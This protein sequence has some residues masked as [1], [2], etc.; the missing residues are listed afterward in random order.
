MFSR[1][2]GNG[3]GDELSRRVRMW[4]LTFGVSKACWEN[5][6]SVES[7]LMGAPFDVACPFA[8]L[9]RRGR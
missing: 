5:S 1:L 7:V 9:A 2:A 6:L 8:L 4:Y 3:L